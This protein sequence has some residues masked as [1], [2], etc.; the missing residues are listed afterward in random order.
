MGCPCANPPGTSQKNVTLR[1]SRALL[2]PLGSDTPLSRNDVRVGRTRRVIQSPPQDA[3]RI[4]PK[5]RSRGLA[6]LKRPMGG[7]L[8]TPFLR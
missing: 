4:G 6:F 7:F 5:N 8:K 1:T 2:E 3:K